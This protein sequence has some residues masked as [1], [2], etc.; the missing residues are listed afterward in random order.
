MT[1]A[2]L[3][4]EAAQATRAGRVLLG[5]AGL[6][7]VGV[8]FFGAA[9]SWLNAIA[10][11]AVSVLLLHASEVEA[12][13]GEVTLRQAQ[14]LE[15][16]D[17]TPCC[18]ALDVIPNGAHFTADTVRIHTPDRCRPLDVWAAEGGAL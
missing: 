17:G 12:G 3:Y 9:Q 16:L 15:A 8:G 1:A 5:L 2:V 18:C 11:A 7:M 13:H 4:A 14:V 6:F 10:C